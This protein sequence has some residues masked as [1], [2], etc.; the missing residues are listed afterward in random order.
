M[1]LRKSK[2]I[3]IRKTRCLPSTR[4]VNRRNIILLMLSCLKQLRMTFP[5]IQ[6]QYKVL[7]QN[8]INHFISFSLRAASS[9]KY[10]QIPSAPA[11]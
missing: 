10:V 3:V 11:R 1:K 7:Y 2:G 5:S 8:Q 4:L 6:F 9:A